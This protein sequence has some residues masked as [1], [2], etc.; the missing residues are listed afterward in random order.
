VRAL[1]LHE[2]LRRRVV[3]W[4]QGTT[5]R[6][7]FTAAK[8][9]TIVKTIVSY[10][11]GSQATTANGRLRTGTISGLTVQTDSAGGNTLD[12]ECAYANLLET[13]QQ[14]C[15]VGGGDFNLVRSGSNVEFRW[16]SG[17]LGTDR[18]S[19]LRFAVER[20]NMGEP[21]AGQ[22]WS[23]ERTVALVGGRGEGSART[24]VVRT[25]AGY[26]SSADSEVWVDAQN[27][28]TTAALNAAGDARLVETQARRQF[29]F[30]V[31]QTPG[32]LYGLH[33]VVG[34]LARATW[35]GTDYD[36]KLKSVQVALGR[37]GET[38]DMQVEVI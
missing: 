2:W 29:S 1:T 14:L 25:G 20:G 8:C 32:C 18:R 9:E 4:Y 26:S 12:W 13:I 15:R 7:V 37:E 36:V 11:A 3:A 27:A 17:Q 22:D 23:E 28:D 5:N 6:S 21:V 19:S 33:Y 24:V 38:V 10:N 34:D 16:Y 35:R 31:L 30:K